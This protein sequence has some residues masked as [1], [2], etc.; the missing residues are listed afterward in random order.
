MKK[1]NLESLIVFLTACICGLLV[2]YILK[3]IYKRDAII[4]DPLIITEDMQII[5]P[6]VQGKEIYGVISEKYLK[7]FLNYKNNR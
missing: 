7:E 3:G 1:E 6:E 5:K 4:K 2:G